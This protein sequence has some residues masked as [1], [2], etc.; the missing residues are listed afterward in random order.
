MRV[1][2]Y[3]LARG[4]EVTATN[5]GRRYGSD[6]ALVVFTVRAPG[7]RTLRI[8]LWNVERDR[9]RARVV[10]MVARLVRLLDLDALALVEASD[11][12]AGLRKVDGLRVLAASVLPGQANTAIVVP[13][14]V[15]WDRFY[16][17][18]MTRAGWVT[19]RGGKT[20]PKYLATVRLDGWLRLAVG[21]RPPSCR[22]H[23][24]GIS[25]PPRRVLSMI[26]HARSEVRWATRKARGALLL[27]E[28]WNATPDARGRWSP[29][30]VAERAGLD[31]VAPRRGTHA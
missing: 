13:D 23:R 11:Y 29:T 18:R 19:V 4:C 5:H 8:G 17:P 21:H 28:D 1:I 27:V 22:W 12:V 31:V 30:W 16:C 10:P 6:H 25:G 15:T 9:N 26:A 24:G 3:A 20:P 14:L 2:D 7:R